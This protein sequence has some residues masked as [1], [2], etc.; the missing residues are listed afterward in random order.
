MGIFSENLR[1]I[2]NLLLL[3]FHNFVSTWEWHKSKKPRKS[4][5]YIKDSSLN[6]RRITI[7]GNMWIWTFPNYSQP[8]T[9]QRSNEFGYNDD[10]IFAKFKYPKSK[11]L[12]LFQWPIKFA[13]FPPKVFKWG[14]LTVLL[15]NYTNADFSL[16]SN[17]TPK[18]W[19]STTFRT[20]SSILWYR[21]QNLGQW[22]ACWYI[23]RC[24]PF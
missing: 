17:E 12:P 21:S 4:E 14:F 2:R 19:D 1:T 13:F 7:L 3:K 16:V 8:S 10:Y 24:L 11:F 6:L 23:I 15:P 18:C 5:Y 20:M 22:S 9:S